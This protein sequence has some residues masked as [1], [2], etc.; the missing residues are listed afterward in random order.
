MN[1]FFPTKYIKITNYY[2]DTHKGIDFGWSKEYGGPNV[3][4]YAINDGVIYK[5][6][7][8]EKGGYC[9]YIKHDDGKVSLYAHLKKDSYRY[10][11]G[12]RVKRRTVV[13]TMGNTGVVTGNHVHLALY[14]KLPLKNANLINPLGYLYA[15]S[16]NIVNAET[17]KKYN[18]KYENNDTNDDLKVGDTVLITG[19]YASSSTATKAENDKLVGS[20]R[21]I[22]KIYKGRNYPYQVGN[23]SGVAGYFKK[24]SLKKVS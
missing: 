14:K 8:Q 20:T 19:N 23:S 24:D 17:K 7:I 2:K 12:D 4:I 3:D 21:S 1:S 5:K 18:I 16:F 11:I 9:L 22:L 15:T 10:N 6:E 13:A